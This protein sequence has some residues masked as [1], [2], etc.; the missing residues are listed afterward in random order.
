MG[1]SR[2]KYQTFSHSH[3]RWCR[4]GLARYGERLLARRKSPILTAQKMFGAIFPSRDLLLSNNNDNNNNNNNN[5]NINNNNNN[6]KPIK[7][8]DAADL[9]II[10]PEPV[11]CPL[12]IRGI[13]GH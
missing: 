4:V 13:H 8:S 10:K 3:T 11:F 9:I 6:N 12:I 5:N 1:W 2:K 7:T